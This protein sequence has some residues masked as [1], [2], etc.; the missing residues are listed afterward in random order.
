MKAALESFAADIN[1]EAPFPISSEEIHHATAVLEAI[2]IS[3]D[4]GTTVEV[5]N[6]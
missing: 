4:T 1:G 6:I 5:A 2:T 3:A